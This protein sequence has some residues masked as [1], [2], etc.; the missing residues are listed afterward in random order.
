MC[1]WGGGVCKGEGCCSSDCN[2]WMLKAEG[3]YHFWF[4]G[5]W[6]ITCY[7][8][9]KALKGEIKHVPKHTPGEKSKGSE[10]KNNSWKKVSLFILVQWTGRALHLF[11]V[12]SDYSN[13]NMKE[14]KIG[15][16]CREKVW[17]VAL[18]EAHYPT[19]TLPKGWLNSITWLH[20]L[21]IFTLENDNIC[22][23]LQF[24]W[25][26]LPVAFHSKEILFPEEISM[27]M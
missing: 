20:A 17:V 12:F 15:V 14:G 16:P 11:W 18:A 2:W 21:Q 23:Y 8:K 26:L 13:N 22:G 25:Q 5:E 27:K 6:V 7:C 3:K 24:L 9:E 1:V 4:E 10:Q 19:G